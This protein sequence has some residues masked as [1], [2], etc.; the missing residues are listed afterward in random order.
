MYLSSRCIAT[1]GGG[2]TYTDT[3]AARRSHKPTLI[4]IPIPLFWKNKRRPMRWPCSLSVFASPLTSEN[5]YHWY[6]T[7]WYTRSRDNVPY[8]REVLPGTSFRMVLIGKE[9]LH[10]T[11]MAC[12]ADRDN[13]PY[14]CTSHCRHCVFKWHS[15]R[16]GL[17]RLV[18]LQY[19]SRW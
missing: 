11:L 2:D 14:T 8:R 18:Y 6:A 1:I 12:T 9:N 17:I 16:K 19:A 10:H 7:A 13:D 15:R 4:F 5:P 3:E